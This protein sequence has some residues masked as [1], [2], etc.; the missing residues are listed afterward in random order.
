MQVEK[1]A[2]E[3]S[4]MDSATDKLQLQQ[5]VQRLRQQLQAAQAQASGSTEDGSGHNLDLN[6]LGEINVLSNPTYA[7]ST[8]SSSYRDSGSGSNNSSTRVTPVA[9]TDPSYPGSSLVTEGLARY[10]A[11]HTVTGAALP[12]LLAAMQCLSISTWICHRVAAW[13]HRLHPLPRMPDVR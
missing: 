5:S 1:K 2:L 13:T 12:M 8:S 4:L 10:S 3:A 11:K 6:V 9:G 7:C